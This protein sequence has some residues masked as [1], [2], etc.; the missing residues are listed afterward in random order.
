MHWLDLDFPTKTWFSK[1]SAPEK[2]KY[3][4]RHMLKPR[5][6]VITEV[7]K[8]LAKIKFPVGALKE[9]SRIRHHGQFKAM[10]F[11]LL[12]FYGCFCF[13]TL[14]KKESLDNFK[15]LALIISKLSAKNVNRQELPFIRRLVDHFL[16][17]F[18]KIYGNKDEHYMWR[19]NVHHVGHLC[20]YVQW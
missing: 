9:M 1:L 2:R 17:T 16:S 13:D 12:L 6:Q 8:H 4:M 5:S 11:E 15:L 20:D 19:S 18:E 10:D 14:I 7:D 3:R